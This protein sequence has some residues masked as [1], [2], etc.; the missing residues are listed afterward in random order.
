MKHLRF[1]LIKYTR[2]N[3]SA[4]KEISNEDINLT[5]ADRLLRKANNKHVIGQLL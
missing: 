1:P 3:A 4:A 2:Q 5:V